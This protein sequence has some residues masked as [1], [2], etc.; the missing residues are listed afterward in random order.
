M[1]IKATEVI[2]FAKDYYLLSND[3]IYTKSKPILIG[4]RI[5]LEYALE[6][7]TSDMIIATSG[8]DRR[9]II[10]VDFTTEECLALANK[11]N[12]EL[13]KLKGIN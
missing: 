5:K 1:K 9:C 2:E 4:G 12:R 7:I 13:M 8:N 10:L 6:G 3:H 11:A